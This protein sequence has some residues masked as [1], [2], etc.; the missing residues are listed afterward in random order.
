[1]LKRGLLSPS[2]NSA[3]VVLGVKVSL[4]LNNII[5]N[6]AIQETKGNKSEM[7]RLLITEAISER[8]DN[9]NLINEM[10]K[11]EF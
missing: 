11:N 7:I 4:E 6:L 8:S 5:E 1:M 3:T 9:E 10:A 2:S